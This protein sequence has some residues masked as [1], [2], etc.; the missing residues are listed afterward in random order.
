MIDGLTVQNNFIHASNPVE[1]LNSSLTY[2]GYV[3]SDMEPSVDKRV[4]WIL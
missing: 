2:H 4:L 1:N 3:F